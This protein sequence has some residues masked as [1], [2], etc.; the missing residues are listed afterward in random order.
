MFEALLITNGSEQCSK[1]IRSS[2]Y[3][4]D[5][6]GGANHICDEP[7][8]MENVLGHRV[9]HPLNLSITSV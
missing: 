1:E 5:S 3:R 7:Q 4:Q 8:E 9:G 2:G 6:E